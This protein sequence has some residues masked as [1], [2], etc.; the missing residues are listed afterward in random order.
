MTNH[1]TYTWLFKSLLSAEKIWPAI[2]NTDFLMKSIG[3]SPVRPMNLRFIERA[4]ISSDHFES[5]DLKCREKYQWEA[6]YHLSIKSFNSDGYFRQLHISIHLTDTDLGCDVSIR[7]K[8]RTNGLTGKLIAYRSFSNSAR[9]RYVKVLSSHG[10]TASTDAESPVIRNSHNVKLP[11]SWNKSYTRLTKNGV[12]ADLS[13]KLIRLLQTSDDQ[14]LKRLYPIR[15]SEIWGRSL[16]DVLKMMFQASKL[17][18]LNHSWIVD[19]PQCKQP[20]KNFTKLSA[21]SPDISCDTC[22]HEFETDL[23]RSVHLSFSPNTAVRKKSGLTFALSNPTHNSDIRLKTYLEPGQIRI[24]KIDLKRG[25]YKITDSKTE[26]VTY[27]TVEPDGDHNASIIFFDDDTDIQNLRLSSNPNLILYNKNRYPLTIECEDLNHELY[28][29]SPVEVTTQPTYCNLFPGEL[30]Q[31]KEQLP[32]RDLTVLFTD[33]SNSSDIYNTRGDDSATGLVM[34]HFDVLEAMIN[35]ERGAIVKTN[36]DSVMALFPKPV[37]A[38]RAFQKAQEAFKNQVETQRSI[39]LKGGIHTGDCVAVILNNRID[40]F[41]A[42]VNIASRLV[43]YAKPEEV[44]ISNSSYLCPELREYLHKDQ[45]ELKMQEFNTK[46]KGFE[47]QIF[48]VKRIS[49]HSSPL[50]LV[51]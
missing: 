13:E 6:P 50:R 43:E 48:E 40:Y 18:I 33:L 27:I 42:T 25:R 3:E 23:H 5:L 17:D 44:I 36:G 41:G 51:V 10:Y 1:F 4:R 47:G 20:A 11:D 28:K 32:A 37:Y 12:D 31:E 30:L 15:L 7:F 46:L 39:L 16:Q 19:C 14:Q 2:S 35:S 45:E 24:I 21:V 38:V 8:G 34:N 49:L 22:G 26:A 9:N 29:I